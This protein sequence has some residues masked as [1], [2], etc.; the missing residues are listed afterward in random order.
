MDIEHKYIDKLAKDIADSID[1][2]VLYKAM[3]WTI[4]SIPFHLFPLDSA[5]DIR[6][7]LDT[8]CG[9]YY[10]WDGQVAFKEGKDATMFLLR[11]GK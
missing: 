4:V 5:T 7:W 9:E 6:G 11:W 1:Q 8:N 10:S 2:Q 3:G